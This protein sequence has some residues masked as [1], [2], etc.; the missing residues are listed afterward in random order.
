MYMSRAWFVEART[1][2]TNAENGTLF[3]WTEGD[4]DLVELT[5]K[6]N[7]SWMQEQME[8]QEAVIDDPTSD[9]IL[10]SADLQT[11]GKRI[12]NIVSQPNPSD[13]GAT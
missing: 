5:L 11:R 1:N 2:M 10:L 7:E 3:P 13:A 8:K 6:D 9:P 4:L 12:Q